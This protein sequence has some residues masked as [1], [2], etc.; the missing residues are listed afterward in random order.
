MIKRPQTKA[1]S[2]A[3]LNPLPKAALVQV[4]GGSSPSIEAQDPVVWM[5]EIVH[6]QS[7]K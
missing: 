3:A 2:R 4:T 6:V 7:L 5:R 1:P